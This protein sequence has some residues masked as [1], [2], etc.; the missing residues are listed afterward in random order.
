MSRSLG[1]RVEEN[2]RSTCHLAQSD[3]GIDL[4]DASTH[5][6]SRLDSRVEL[7]LE[8]FRLSLGFQQIQR[9]SGNL[10]VSA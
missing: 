5:R 6:Q 4:V 2:E 1:R 3:L 10:P 8:R 9:Q 7:E